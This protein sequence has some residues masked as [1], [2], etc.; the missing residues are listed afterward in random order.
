M[1]MAE[2][3]NLAAQITLIGMSLVFGSIVLLWGVMAL[4]VRLTSDKA[5]AE[6]APPAGAEGIQAPKSDDAAALHDRRR[7]A[8][9][10]AAMFALMKARSSEQEPAELTLPPTAI[11]SA[12]QAVLR[13][14]NI[15]QRG[16]IRR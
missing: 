12:W 9:T 5:P 8:A 4:L 6:S 10:I 13:S 3:L 7:K 2:N 15:R 16:S 1:N 14:S 11:V